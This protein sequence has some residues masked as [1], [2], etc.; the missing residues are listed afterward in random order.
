MFSGSGKGKNDNSGN[1]IKGNRA[2][3]HKRSHACI[4]V[5]ILNKGN[6]QNSSAASVRGL[7]KFSHIVLFMV[8]LCCYNPD[9]NDADQCSKK[10]EKNIF[11]IPD[12]AKIG[13]AQILKQENGQ[14]YL[15]VKG[16]QGFYKGIIYQS[17]LMKKI[18]K[19]HDQ[20]NGN[21]SIEAENK[22]IHGKLLFN[23]RFPG[24]YRVLCR[25][26]Q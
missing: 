7:Y 25:I 23:I 16:V 6:S 18:A 24:K 4:S 22:I 15:K 13:A 11:C 17:D 10:T 1:I 19:Y 9:K 5:D 3:D 26:C 8:Q 14:S 2:D 20:K 12:G 21:S